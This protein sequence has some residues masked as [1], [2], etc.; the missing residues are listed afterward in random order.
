MKRRNVRQ[1]SLTVS[2]L[3]LFLA[4][5]TIFL[6]SSCGEK[7]V[8]GGEGDSVPYGIIID[9]TGCKPSPPIQSADTIPPNRDCL[10]YSYLGENRILRVKHINAVFNCC[11][12]ISA[13]IGILGDTILIKENES[14]GPDGPCYCLCYYD[15]LY[16][17][18]NLPVGEYVIRIIE[19]Y[20]LGNELP[21]AIDADLEQEPMGMYCI[22]RDI[23]PVTA[24]GYL[25]GYSGCKAGDYSFDGGRFLSPGNC[26]TFEYDGKKVL[27]L[28][29]INAVFN[30]CP[31]SILADI[32]ISHDSITITER[33]LHSGCRCLCNYDLN[34]EIINLKPD[35]YTFTFITP[36]SFPLMEPL[37]FT[38]DL[39]VDTTGVYCWQGRWGPM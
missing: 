19:A 23:I 4:V 2:N 26:I 24:S 16:E 14:Y 35:D 20:T 5:T 3:L 29:H 34:Y 10:E 25:K 11:A 17:I 36:Y 1:K 30:C 6:L 33:E 8:T 39:R 37:M 13:D 32:R 7:K 38:I 27:H 15:V 12:I 22:E 31:D 9:K 18:R 21:L 28:K